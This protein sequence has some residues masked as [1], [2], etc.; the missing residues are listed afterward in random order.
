[1][2]A[3]HV[4][5][6]EE[7]YERVAGDEEL[8]QEIIELFMEDYQEHL[9]NINTAIATN[10]AEAL[11]KAA[12][13]LKG[14]VATFAAAKAKDAAFVL[15]KMGRNNDLTGGLEAYQTLVIE[16][17][18]LKEALS[19]FTIPEEIEKTLDHEAIF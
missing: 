17:Q 9:D 13:T 14:A 7:L 2:Q 1:M 8:L 16:V 11:T 15:E 6:V 5:N 18:H 10:D 4:L 3:D 19:Q 12:H